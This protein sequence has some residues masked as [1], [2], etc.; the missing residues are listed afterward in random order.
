MAAVSIMIW[1]RKRRIVLLAGAMAAIAFIFSLGPR[2]YVD[3]HNTD[4]PLPFALLAHIPIAGGLVA[5]R[6]SLFIDLFVA[7]VL[8]AGL[9]E[10]HVR[11][12]QSDVNDGRSAVG[13]S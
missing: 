7:G 4:I 3:G 9:D 12:K 2:L 13:E 5:I 11:I 6:F 1:L 8:A 10:L